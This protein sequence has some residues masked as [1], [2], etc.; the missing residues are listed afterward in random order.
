[1]NEQNPEKSTSEQFAAVWATLGHNQKRFVIAMLECK[2]KKEAAQS[3]GIKPDTAY[4]WN[5]LVDKV[6]ELARSDI[7]SAAVGIIAAA[8]SKAAAI[9]A[10]GLDSDNER[11]RQD[12]ATEILDRNMGKPTQR[13]ELTGKDGG[14]VTIKYIAENRSSDA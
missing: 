2:T 1:M 10:G 13:Q 6:I 5:E 12:S 11:I 14:E 9:K 3:I 8:G 7:Q 4:H